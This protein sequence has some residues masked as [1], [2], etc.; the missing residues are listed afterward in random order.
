[1][2]KYNTM[3]IVGFILSF[4]ISIVGLILSIIGMRQCDERGEAGKGLAV[5]GVI[6]SALGLLASV[7]LII[8]PLSCL[9]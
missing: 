8:A 9:I 2:K 4:F 1:M 7:I 3:S 6:I 5:A